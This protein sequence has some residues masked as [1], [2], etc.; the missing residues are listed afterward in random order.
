MDLIQQ[1]IILTGYKLFVVEEWYLS[2]RKFYSTFLVHTGNE[3]DK[4]NFP[5]FFFFIL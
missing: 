5:A 2:P 1:D 4:V 3:D